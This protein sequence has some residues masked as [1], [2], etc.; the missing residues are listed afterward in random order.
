[1]N[2]IDT[3][4][5]PISLFLRSSAYS[6]AQNTTKTNLL[7]ELNEA[8]T[9]YQNMDMLVSCNSFQFTNSFY[10]INEY[11]YKFIYK[12][13][14]GSAITVNIPYGYYDI[15]SLILK[16]NTLLTGIFTFSYNSLTYKI[17]ISHNT[18]LTFIL[19]DDGNSLN[20]YETLGIPDNGFSTYTSLYDCPYLFNL[21]SVQVLHICTP[22]INIKSVSLKDTQKYNIIASI[23]V[24]SQ[25]GCV[26]TYLSNNAFEYLINDDVVSFINVIILDQDFNNVSFNNI[27]WFLNLT[28]KFVYK[29]VLNIPLSLAQYQQEY[30]HSEDEQTTMEEEIVNQENINY[31]NSLLLNN[32]ST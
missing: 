8:I 32:I 9:N 10:T 27:D 3:P 14:G 31:F 20:I 4:I 13:L 26:Q 6:V 16:L 22:N 17:T 21:M 7:F 1:M 18:N 25:F 23:L 29:K 5:P 12:I 19:L 30:K 2:I 11:N 28:F 24:T 15:D